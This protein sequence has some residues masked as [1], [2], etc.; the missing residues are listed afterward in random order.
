[1]KLPPLVTLLGYAGLLPFIVEP[2]WLTIS[3]QSA[4]VWLDHVWLKYAGLMAA[5]M[6]GTFWGLALIVIE[7]PAGLFGLLLSAALM[8]LAWFAV[9][10]PFRPA[11]LALAVV[12]A[13]LGAAEIWRERTLD[14][15]GSYFRLRM[16]LTGGV[17][18]CLVWRFALG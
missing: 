1:M 4:P 5:F 14:P 15:V 16:V 6:A 8:L 3:P 18:I 17:L 13:L 12:F 7:N 11:L 10:L 2:L 9:L